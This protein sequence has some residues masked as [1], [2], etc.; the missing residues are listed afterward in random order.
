[1]HLPAHAWTCSA[2]KRSKAV[3]GGGASPTIRKHTKKKRSSPQVTLAA[4]DGTA[5]RVE[6]VPWQG[7]A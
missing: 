1:M 7:P 2:G 3:E 6:P 4:A 5:G